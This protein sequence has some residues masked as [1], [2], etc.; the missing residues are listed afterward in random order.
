MRRDCSW[1]ITIGLNKT[2]LTDK[3]NYEVEILKVGDADTILIREYI[4]NHP[5]VILIDAGNVGDGNNII[6]PHLKSYYSD[7]FKDDGK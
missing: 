6:I 2:N 1:C 3:M 7:I 5:Y 4:N